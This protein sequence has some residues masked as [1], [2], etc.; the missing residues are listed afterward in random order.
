MPDRIVT[1]TMNP[2]LDVSTAVNQVTPTHKLRCEAAQMHPGGGGINVARVIHRLGTDC[3]ALFPSGGLNGKAIETRLD[4]EGVPFQSIPIAQESRESFSVHERQT[5]L[6]YRFVVPGPKLQES[7]WRACLTAVRSLRP[8]PRYLVASGSLPPGVPQDFYAQLGQLCRTQDTLL[9][10]DASGP[11]LL[12]GLQAGVYVFKPSLRELRELTGQALTTNAERIQ[13]ARTLIEQGQSE[14]VALSL[15][16]EGAMLITRNQ[17]WSAP[18]LPVPVAS[19]IGAGDSFLA[20]LIWA[21]SENQPLEQAFAQALATATAALLSPGTALGQ[22]QD[23]ADLL[24]QVQ[25]GVC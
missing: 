24:A 23:I 16:D 11:A 1:V 4:A 13:A 15:G 17:A 21:L 10:L 12:A 14:I 9:A 2:A 8:V 3:L 22:P 19:T 6:D 7:E 18:A 25:I 5:G 20:G